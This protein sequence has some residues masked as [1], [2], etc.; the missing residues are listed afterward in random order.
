MSHNCD[1]VA[2][3][4]PFLA[5]KH[6]EALILCIKSL[7]KYSPFPYE[8][9]IQIDDTNKELIKE[10]DESE[11]REV[12]PEAK[13]RY[14][15]RTRSGDYK[16][17]L[18]D[19]VTQETSAGYVIVLHSD[20]VLYKSDA[21]SS[22]VDAL[23]TDCSAL[24]ATW[25]IQFSE[26]IS[27]Y[28]ISE[29]KKKHFY[30]APRMCTWLFALNTENYRSARLAYDHLLLGHYWIRNG[31]LQEVP[32]PQGRFLAWLKSFDEYD[33]FV[34]SGLPCLVDIGTFARFYADAGDLKVVY[35]GYEHNPGLH[36]L[37]PSFAD[38]GYIHLEQYDPERFNESLYSA[39]LMEFRARTVAMLMEKLL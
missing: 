24:A 37:E 35:L 22:L 27:T 1:L 8:L 12:C 14:R 7:A 34:A 17:A 15:T 20:V 10:F 39:E 38:A 4:I 33:T 31:I 5:S 2:Y 13:I 11:L 30:V 32:V 18:T 25:K 21:V 28:H 29:E 23:S 16:Q 3:A 19:W 9:F 36:S 6:T 26:Y